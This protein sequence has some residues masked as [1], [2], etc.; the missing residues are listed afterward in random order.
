MGPGKEGGGQKPLWEFKIKDIRKSF[1]V[2]VIN[3]FLELTASKKLLEKRLMKIP[4]VS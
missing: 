4:F 2:K 3:V 1:L